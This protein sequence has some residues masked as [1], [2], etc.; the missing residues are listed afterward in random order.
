M[1]ILESDISVWKSLSVAKSSHSTHKIKGFFF[2]LVLFTCT[3]CIA[4]YPRMRRFTIHLPRRDSKSG[5]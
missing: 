2:P 4:M 1:M 3:Y 5:T